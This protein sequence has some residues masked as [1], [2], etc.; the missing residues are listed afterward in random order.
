MMF[1]TSQYVAADVSKAMLD[2]AIP[3]AN[4][5]WRSA[6]TPAMALRKNAAGPDY[7]D[8]AIFADR[9]EAQRTEVG[10]RHPLGRIANPNEIAALVTWLASPEASFVTGG[11]YPIDGGYLAR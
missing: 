6:N 3:G 5:V 1:N 8:T 10:M 4:R 7:V 2:V 9:T 11:Y